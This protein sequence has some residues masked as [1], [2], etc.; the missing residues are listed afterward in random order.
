MKQPNGG[1]RMHVEGEIDVRA[2]YT[3]IS[4]ASVLNI[5]DEELTQNVGDYILSCQTYEGGIAGEPGSEAHGGYTFCGLAAMI[6][7]GEVNRLDLPRLVEWTV[8]RQGKECG[9][10]GRT[11]KLVDGCY[12]FWQVIAIFCLLHQSSVT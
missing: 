12:S 7:I 11:N 3:A 4:V 8:F 1:F 5:L 6:L 9:F 2:C 10:Q